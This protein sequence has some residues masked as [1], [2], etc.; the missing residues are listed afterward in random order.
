MHQ[1]VENVAFGENGPAF[2]CYS[3]SRQGTR[4][5]DGSIIFE[6]FETVMLEICSDLKVA[7][8]TPRNALASDKAVKPA[9]AEAY[10]Q[11]RFG[12]TPARYAIK[13]NRILIL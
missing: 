10:V 11:S 8:L 12:A 2:L 13:Y 4:F 1:V 9:R 3:G 7:T 6:D 5:V